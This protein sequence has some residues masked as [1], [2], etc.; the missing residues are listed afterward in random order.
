MGELHSNR[1]SFSSIKMRHGLRHSRKL[2]CNYWSHQC[3]LIL[4]PLIIF[5]DISA[6]TQTVPMDAPAC[7]GD[8]APG[9][10]AYAE[11][12]IHSSASDW[13][14]DVNMT[15][16]MYAN[17]LLSLVHLNT[18]H[19]TA[20]DSLLTAPFAWPSVLMPNSVTHRG[21]LIKRYFRCG[22]CSQR[23]WHYIQTARDSL[24][25]PMRLMQLH[26]HVVAVI[27]SNDTWYIADADYGVFAPLD[28]WQQSYHFLREWP[29]HYQRILR[30]Y[31]NANVTHSYATL[32]DL[33]A[34]ERH[35]IFFI[36]DVRDLIIILNVL[37]L[38]CVGVSVCTC[39]RGLY[40]LASAKQPL[41]DQCLSTC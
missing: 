6:L 13:K 28:E 11:P 35:Q 9:L 26:E 14:R 15:D 23:A 20:R 21:L 33:E 7:R 36:T 41:A 3:A 18:Y 29:F 10:R 22:L 25:M 37:F 38:V 31:D 8:C 34:N 24:A 30:A 19:C 4:L 40:N 1:L 5:I 17:K 12:A 27:Y 32:A 2:G 39:L 16:L